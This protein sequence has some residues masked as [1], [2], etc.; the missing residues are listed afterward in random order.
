AGEEKV[1]VFTP[2][3][4]KELNLN[5][6]KLWWPNGYGAQN[7]YNLRLKASVNDHLSDSK[8]VRFGIRELS[9]ELM[10]NTE[11]KGNHRVLYT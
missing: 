7:L 2:E 1:L 4:H 3:T 8:T 9:Y 11:D 6:P 5:H 10:V